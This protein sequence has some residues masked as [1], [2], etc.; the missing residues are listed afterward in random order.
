MAR[1]RHKKKRRK[2]LLSLVPLFNGIR[3]ALSCD[4]AD[5]AMQRQGIGMNHQTGVI[6]D[7]A[8]PYMFKRFKQVEQFD[9]RVIW[10]EDPPFA[11]LA[12][13]SFDDFIDSQKTFHLPEPMSRRAELVTSEARRIVS[14]ILGHFSYDEWFDSCSFG[15]RAATGLPRSQS[16]LDT[17]FKRLSGTE[18]QVTCFKA[19]L[20]RDIHL[21]R[22]VRKFCR[23]FRILTKVSAAAVPKSYKAA[24]IMFPDTPIGGFLSKGLGRLMRKRLE[25]NTHIDLAKQQH[26][27]RKWAQEASISG[28]LSTID[29]S[30]ASDSFVWRHMEMLVPPDWWAA[31]QTVHVKV[32]ELPNGMLIPLNSFMLMGSGHTFPL[33]TILFYSLAEAT[34]TLLKSRGKVSVYGDD[35][36]V[37][38]RIA[39]QLIEVFGELGFTI[40]SE[41]SFFD[42]PDPER[43]SH[44]FFRESCGGD[45]KGGIDVRPYMPECDLQQDGNVSVGEYQAW[46]HKSINGFLDRWDVHEIP[47]V[48]NFL[49]RA[50]SQTGKGYICFVPEDE[51]DHA[52]I[53]HAIPRN[54]LIGLNVQT[55][56]Y[57]GWMADLPVITYV[58]NYWK[59]VFKQAKRKRRVNER[60]YQW[61]CYWLQRNRPS[62]PPPLRATKEGDVTPEDM[63]T[64]TISLSGENRKD[65]RGEYRW[66]K[67]VQ[68]L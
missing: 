44:T 19:C 6:N 41:K 29:M 31:L 23:D 59:L 28:H 14:S 21:H 11:L 10:P 5:A 16:Y 36:I 48:V 67:L 20:A 39:S 49:L 24:R 46:I 55:V 47:S 61:Y 7:G 68:R 53:K 18:W 65:I 38:T 35:I 45:F 17:R 8:P 3:E 54:F 15:S 56:S 25:R 57:S 66:K 12:S 62:G 43:P 51:V 60:P 4:L 22:G 13:K 64:R 63:Y 33:Q 37:P 32:C 52:G 27:H 40:N 2:Q 1:K 34:R 30:K 42:K 58:P 9:K 26:R 50:L